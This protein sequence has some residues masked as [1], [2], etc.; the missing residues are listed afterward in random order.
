MRFNKTID[1]L[2]Q[3]PVVTVIPEIES[4]SVTLIAEGIRLYG[5]FD[6]MDR[7]FVAKIGSDLRSADGEVLP[8]GSRIPFVMPKR[9]PSVSFNQNQ[10]VLSPKGNLEIGLK[11]CSI[12]NV[13][14]SATKI[15]SLIHI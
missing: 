14:L 11:T 10:G 4:L 13:R 3:K 2:Q 6:S 8:A 15:L 5:N 9:Y 1:L 7:H 12:S